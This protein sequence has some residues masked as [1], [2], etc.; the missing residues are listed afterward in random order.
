M[1]ERQRRTRRCTVT[2]AGELMVRPTEG[3]A[4]AMRSRFLVLAMS[5]FLVA[6]G[7]APADDA[8]KADLKP[9]LE[10]VRKL[11]EKHYPKAKVT[12]KDRTIHFEFNTRKY[13]IHEALM[14]GE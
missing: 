1:A 7:C 14:T 12:L 8:P 6:S 11:V 10:E 13:M 2:A 9:F 4:M 5:C 3:I